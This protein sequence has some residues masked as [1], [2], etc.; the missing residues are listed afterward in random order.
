[1]SDGDL[2]E[3]GWYDNPE[4][5]GERYWNGHKWTGQYRSLQPDGSE[6]G[7][8]DDPEGRGQR[9]WDGQRWT[10]KASR[11]RT[12]LVVAGLVLAIPV[13]GAVLGVLSALGVLSDGEQQP[14]AEG[15]GGVERVIPDEESAP[16]DHEGEEAEGAGSG[17][18]A[19]SV[20]L[21]DA[22][23]EGLDIQGGGELEGGKLLPVPG[24]LRNSEGWPE[25]FVAPRIV[26]PGMGDDTIGVWATGQGGG[27]IIAVN[28]MAQAFSVWGDAAQPGSPMANFRD[29]LAASER[30]DETE[31]CV[32]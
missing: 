25:R 20:S 1:M 14:V 24:G 23:S 6:A 28:R 8:Y 17:C 31:A 21:L 19:A 4:G 10:K 27:P 30:A 22:I 29:Q 13:A 32:G 12:P 15:A 11:W 2:P 5:D 3:A 16:G 7:W 26:G 9:Y 18:K